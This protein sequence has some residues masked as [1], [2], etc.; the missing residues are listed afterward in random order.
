M[1]GE[2]EDAGAGNYGFTMA[3]TSNGGTGARPQKDGLSATAYPSGVKGTPVE[4][5]ESIH[6][7]DVLAQGIP[8]RFR[9]CGPHPWRPWTGDRGGQPHWQALWTCWRPSTGSDHPP[10]G[11]DGGH[12][13]AAG[14][15][16]FKSGKVLKGKGFQTIPPNERLVIMTPGGGGLGDPATRDEAALRRDLEEGLVSE[17]GAKLYRSPSQAGG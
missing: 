10:R 4:I 16:A 11:W 17:E 14:S 15:V 13:G 5:A 9:W 6:A 8:H 7:A 12:N 1:R 2:S 3:V